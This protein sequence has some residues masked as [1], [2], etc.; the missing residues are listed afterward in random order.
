MDKSLNKFLT[1]KEVCSLSGSEYIELTFYHSEDQ[2]PYRHRERAKDGALLTD[3]YLLDLKL[4]ALK[5]MYPA[6]TTQAKRDTALFKAK[7]SEY[8]QRAIPLI[9][10]E[11]IELRENAQPTTVVNNYYCNADAADIKNTK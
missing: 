2:I 7:L 5:S 4:L 10:D 8:A 1:A 6:E 3:E 9:V 11:L